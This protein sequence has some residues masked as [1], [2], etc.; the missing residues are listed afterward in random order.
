METKP[1]SVIWFASI[2]SQYVGCLFILFVVSFAVQ[3][4][5]SLSRSHLF[6][7]AFIFIILGDRLKKML[8]WFIAESVLPMF[9]SKSFTVSSL[10]F[11]SLAYFE[12]IFVYGVKEWSNVI[13]YMWLSSS[14]STICWRDCL[15][16]LMY[17]CLLCHRLTTGA[18]VYFWVFY[19]LHWYLYLLCQCHTVLMTVA[20]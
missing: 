7:F 8:P 2:F 16:N 1:L 6:I 5:L 4:L 10:A 17:S 13:F 14:P 18:W 20:L 15:S 12:L 11:R 3:K 19:L 9:S